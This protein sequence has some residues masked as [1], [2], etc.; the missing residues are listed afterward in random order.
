MDAQEIPIRAT[1]LQ[2]LLGAKIVS[3]VAEAPDT[4]VL[5]FSNS[6]I[7]RLIDD[8]PRYES[9]TISGAPGGTIIV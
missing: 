6:E 7:L 9:F 8:S 2:S 1:S 3:C 4:L 5:T